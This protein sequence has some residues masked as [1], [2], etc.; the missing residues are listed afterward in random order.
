MYKRQIIDSLL[1]PYYY[2]EVGFK[3]KEDDFILNV[4]D[5]KTYSQLSKKQIYSRMSNY[6]NTLADAL[7]DYIATIHNAPTS[8]TE[9]RITYYAARHTALNVLN[10]KGATLEEIANMA[11]HDLKTLEKSYLGDFN[12]K[13]KV[14]SNL[15]IWENEPIQE[16]AIESSWENQP[17]QEETIEGSWENQS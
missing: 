9:K 10:D 3:K 8:L 6:W 15:R 17:R 13:R 4:F 2:D 16:E 5:K 11:G 7:N 14:E 1:Y 12:I